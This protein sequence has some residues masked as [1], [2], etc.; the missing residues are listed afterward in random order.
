MITTNLTIEQLDRF[1]QI[2][3]FCDSKL[4]KV[5]AK[6]LPTMYKVFE[7]SIG[8]G[9]DA[10][11]IKNS[12]KH[13]ARLRITLTSRQLSIYDFVLILMLDVAAKDRELLYLR[14]FPHRLS[15]R[16]LKRMYLDWSHTKI[17]YEYNKSL[18]KVCKVA[19]KNLKKYLTS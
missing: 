16:Q 12:Q 7:N 2:A 14:N 3:S 6:S 4:P 18:S 8:I 19:N 1:L 10:E 9:D 15:L 5:K 11:S 13:L 17:G